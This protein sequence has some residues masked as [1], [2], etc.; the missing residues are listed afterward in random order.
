MAIKNIFTSE[1]K[2]VIRK[3]LKIIKPIYHSY[4]LNT[5]S[6]KVREFLIQKI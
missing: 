5:V 6:M 1:E 3:F 2:F 4:I